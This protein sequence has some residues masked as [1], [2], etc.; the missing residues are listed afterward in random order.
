MVLVGASM[1][2]EDLTSASILA[3]ITSPPKSI[4]Q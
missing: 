1:C 3:A 2:P 4:G